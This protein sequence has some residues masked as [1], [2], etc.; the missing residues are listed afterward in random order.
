MRI[1]I[2]AND[3]CGAGTI[4]YTVET[5]EY[6]GEAANDPSAAMRAAEA[7]D[8]PISATARPGEV[9]QL[10][11]PGLKDNSIY[12]VEISASDAA[13]NKSAENKT[14]QITTGDTT[15]GIGS[16]TTDEIPAETVVYDLNGRR[17]TH[18]AAGQ[19]YIVNGK[20]MIVR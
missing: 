1:S 14:L 6:V 5:L 9:A 20:K 16:I 2:K 8:T 4:T 13:G 19:I 17:V 15:S 7:V 11:I 10:D 18:P 3:N 12:N